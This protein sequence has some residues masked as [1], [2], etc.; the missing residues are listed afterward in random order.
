MAVSF[1]STPCQLPGQ[2]VIQK[3]PEL[4]SQL[5]RPLRHG[6]P[7]SH[8]A[9]KRPQSPPQM[10]TDNDASRRDFL[11]LIGTAAASLTLPVGVAHSQNMPPPRPN[12]VI[13]D[14]KIG[15]YLPPRRVQALLEHINGS[16]FNRVVAVGETHTNP[17]CGKLELD[18]IRSLARLDD[19]RKLIVGFECFYRQHNP[20][21][22]RFVNGNI[23][24]GKMLKDT[25]WDKTW[26]FDVKQWIDIFRFCRIHHIPMVGL[27]IPSG[28]VDL[29]AKEG[30]DGLPEELKE[31]LPDM[32]LSNK[33]HYERFRQAMDATLQ[34]HGHNMP[35]DTL[36]NWYSCTTLW[37]EFMAES[38]ALQLADPNARVCCVAGTFHAERTGIPDRI[39][40]RTSEPTFSIVSR[41]V[42]FD[43]YNMPI[44][45]H[46]E[47]SE[48]ADWLWYIPRA[49]D[50]V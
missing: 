34:G 18:V 25:N 44:I 16:R 38:V 32:D 2:F 6:T 13:F 33:R 50:M 21:L 40:R 49:I 19:G 1:L 42:P 35:S 9:R 28:F 47:K 43:T 14:T 36:A 39:T 4:L 10:S 41:S 24:M 20:V 5:S 12:E 27:N 30:L 11:R 31:F 23:S 37:D 8:H 15:S 45:D 7:S 26:G 3:S 46:P 22:A 17:R 48:I 29:V